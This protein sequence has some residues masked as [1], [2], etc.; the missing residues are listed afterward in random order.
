MP[1]PRKRNL[2]ATVHGMSIPIYATK[3][4]GK[5]LF[6][7]A[8]HPDGGK[9]QIKSFVSLDD[10][11]LHGQRMLTG[12]AQVRMIMAQLSKEQLESACLLGELLL[13]FV[14]KL[15]I[16]LREAV[17]EY[18]AARTLTGADGLV[19]CLEKHFAQ[20]WVIKSK[21]KFYRAAGRFMSAKSRA[22]RHK[23]TIS[24]FRYSLRPIAKTLGNPPLNEIT[25]AMLSRVVFREDLEPIAQRTIYRSL[26]NFYSWLERN[27]YIQP[28]M[29][30]P[31]Q[32]VEAPKVPKKPPGILSVPT[33]RAALAALAAD[34]Y[35]HRVAFLAIALFSGLRMCELAKLDWSGIDLEGVRVSVVVSK[36]ESRRQILLSPVLRAWLSPFL[37]RVSGRIA[38]A[39]RSQRRISEILA[40][41]GI[42]WPRNC[43]RHSYSSYRLALTG[44]SNLTKAETGNSLP[45][46]E[47]HYH[48]ITSKAAAEAY[49]SL[50]PEACGI[51]DWPARAEKF[52]AG[53][54]RQRAARLAQSAKVSSLARREF[55][56]E[57]EALAC[58]QPRTTRADV[59]CMIPKTLTFQA[60]TRPKPNVAELANLPN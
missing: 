3:S 56:N 6:Q 47:R 43:L 42:A 5:D 14:K 17:E 32:G 16:S 57:P 24:K 11:K 48:C 37:G 23:N 60:E 55:P 34:P 21:T 35:C 26:T 13:P 53:L 50:T 36:T 15:G 12:G 7:I 27:E 39:E 31:I 54:D 33:T 8:E 28:K 45:M 9:R 19:K 29:P 25:P 52:L 4:H 59:N 10:A 1:K 46:L 51:T 41:E 58:G 44:D 18:V 40:K 49:F 2:Y 38:S 30:T 20:P 22:G